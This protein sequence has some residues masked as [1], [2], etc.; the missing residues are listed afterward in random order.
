MS[1][2]AGRFIP[3][4]GSRVLMHIPA[5]ALDGPPTHYQEVDGVLF[6]ATSLSEY[7][8]DVL[9][10]ADSTTEGQI[11]VVRLGPRL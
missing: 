11:Q 10:D 5:G 1:S 3:D 8:V 6:V 7:R 4:E 2:D 9:F